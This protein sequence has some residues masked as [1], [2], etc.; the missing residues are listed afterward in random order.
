MTLTLEHLNNKALMDAINQIEAVQNESIRMELC[1]QL[2]ETFG[3]DL[4][5]H[6]K[7]VQPTTTKSQPKPNNRR[8]GVL[9]PQEIYA[10]TTDEEFIE[11]FNEYNKNVLKYKASTIERHKRVSNHF[12]AWYREHGLQKSIVDIS[13]TEAENYLLY[14]KNQKNGKGNWLSNGAVN[15]YHKSVSKLFHFLNNLEILNPHILMK[16]DRNHFAN[17]KQLNEKTEDRRVVSDILK[18]YELKLLLKAVKDTTRG[19]TPFVIARN[20]FLF[21]L[22]M[23]SG[24]RISETCDLKLSDVDHLRG[25]VRV[26]DGKGGKDRITLFS[27]RLE[28]EYEDYLKL[29]MAIDTE[30][31]N[32]FV[33]EPRMVKG[34]LRPAKKICRTNVWQYLKKYLDEIEFD[35]NER[36]ITLHSLRHS[37]VS[38]MVFELGVPEAEV[39]EYCGHSTVKIT[40][41]VYAHHII[42]EEVQKVNDQRFDRLGL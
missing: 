12:L 9:T 8:E 19:R 25:I 30:L 35:L 36:N 11:M 7:S 17:I 14:V 6:F 13:Y 2:N 23:T 41:D 28:E 16:E 38:M 37:F 27:K 18:S 26:I 24:L 34:E 39:S 42:D 33:T 5:D 31:D 15:N 40:R 20:H 3:V 29:R 1:N 4:T 22:M 32:L 21:R 10:E